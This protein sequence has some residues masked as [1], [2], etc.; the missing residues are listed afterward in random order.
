MR[1][2][3]VPGLDLAIDPKS[4][5]FRCTT[6][7]YMPKAHFLLAAI[8]RRG[9]GKT[10]YVTSFLEK[11]ECVDRL[12]LVSPSARSNKQFTDRLK[13]MLAEEDTYDNVDDISI[14]DDIV[15]KVEQE[16]DDLEEYLAK[17]KK[18]E[19]L[20]KAIKSPLFQISDDDLLSAYESGRFEPPKHKWGGRIPFLVVFFDDVI[21]T[22]IT[23]GKG[24]RQMTK[25]ALTH[26]H[27]GQFETGGAVGLSLIWAAQSYRT[28]QGGI[29]KAIRN[30]LTL[31]LIFKTKS[32]REL[33]E[34]AD[35]AAG[36]VDRETF[37]RIYEA[38]IQGPH[39]AL[40]IDL[41]PKKEH[42]SGFRR[43]LNEFLVPE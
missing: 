36:Q 41:N 23:L 7:T 35:E 13:D 43:A 19:R 42:P 5:A 32:E 26:R 37:F 29:P 6:P 10:S 1:R 33:I 17:K 21:A 3:K 40:L 24:A 2:V 39:D 22:P 11:L 38:A 9:Q 27:L 14:L 4:T 18:Y 16:R 12:F 15:R 20:M 25:L 28:A 8:G 31:I 30:N 34:I